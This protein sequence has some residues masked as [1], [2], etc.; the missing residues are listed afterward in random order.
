MCR[1]VKR[2][3]KYA[4]DAPNAFISMLSF[5]ER[6]AIAKAS[7]TNILLKDV[8]MILDGTHTPIQIH[9]KSKEKVKRY[10]SFKLKCSALNTVCGMAQNGQ[11]LWVSETY[12]AGA[13]PDT[14][15]L[16]VE[17]D[18]LI[19]CIDSLDF[20]LGDRRMFGR[21]LKEKINQQLLTGN[22]NNGHLTVQQERKN[23][24]LGAE[25]AKVE[26]GFKDIKNRFQILNRKWR[27]PEN[28][29]NTALK[30][31]L[32]WKNLMLKSNQLSIVESNQLGLFRQHRIPFAPYQTEIPDGLVRDK[33]E[34]L[35]ERKRKRKSE[36]DEY[37]KRRRE[38]LL[39]RIPVHPSSTSSS[40][41]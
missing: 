37:E 21:E 20:L 39:I 4:A 2:I 32:A 36:E 29:F 5:K 14:S 3:L 33:I 18:K 25:R 6:E 9:E 30:F 15:I 10:W 11:W 1:L 27:L 13:F 35:Q 12:P 17:S 23:S 19:G 40:S 38:R 31:C 28:L 7:C 16:N 8:T 24:I 26:H 22:D 41:Q 34:D